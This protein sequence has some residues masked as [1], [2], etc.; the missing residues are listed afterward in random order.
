VIRVRG[1]LSRLQLAL[2]FYDLKY[3]KNTTKLK[4]KRISSGTLR[5]GIVVRVKFDDMNFKRQCCMDII[6]NGIS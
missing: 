1:G 2:T 6:A 5:C 3:N 4:S